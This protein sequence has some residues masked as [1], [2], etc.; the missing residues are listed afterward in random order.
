MAA[1]TTS[2]QQVSV[3]PRSVVARGLRRQDPS[4]PRS[5]EVRSR[6]A[7][8]GCPAD[9]SAARTTG[10]LLFPR[11]SSG[12]GGSRFP[13]VLPIP[14]PGFDPNLCLPFSPEPH[15]PRRQVHLRSRVAWPR[16]SVL[17]MLLVPVAASPDSGPGPQLS[18]QDPAGWGA[19]PGSQCFLFRG[20][21]AARPIPSRG[22][23]HSR[24]TLFKPLAHGIRLSKA[25]VPL[26]GQALLKV[27]RGARALDP[28]RGGARGGGGS[29]SHVGADAGC[30]AT[31][32]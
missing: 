19:L 16:T 17:R 2:C 20:P 5:K 6:P 9:Y 12:L 30:S 13:G 10:G 27:P 4:S 15:S 28:R 22:R 25:P 24:G 26:G 21:G 29:V 7:T 11:R 8:A 3:R 14:Q 1:V 31:L 32:A 23:F 18:S